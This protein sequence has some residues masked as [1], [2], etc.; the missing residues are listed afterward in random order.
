M[1]DQIDESGGSPSRHKVAKEMAEY[2]LGILENKDSGK[3][4]RAE[5]LTAVAQC[6]RALRGIAP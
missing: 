3:I 6:V 5:Y 4:T 2:I 1:A